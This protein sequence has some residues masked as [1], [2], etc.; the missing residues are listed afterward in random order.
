MKEEKLKVDAVRELIQRGKEKGCL[1]YQEIMDTLQGIELSADQIDDIYEHF[2]ALGIE[3]LPDGGSDEPPIE[4][5][6]EDIPQDE[7]IEVDLSIPE[8]IAID[9]P[10]RMYLKEIGRI[11]F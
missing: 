6:I 3:I 9:D 10:V 7:E 2:G 4:K 8:G 1:T 5:E 11:P